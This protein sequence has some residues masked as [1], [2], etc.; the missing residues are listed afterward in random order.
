M[1]IVNITNAHLYVVFLVFCRLGSAMMFFPL[2]AEG[3][4]NAQA[5]LLFG[6]LLSYLI[7]PTVMHNFPD[8][9]VLASQIVTLIANE[10]FMGVYL[11]TITRIFINTLH[12]VGM[13]ISTQMGILMATLFDPSQ[14]VQNSIPGIILNMT[15]IAIFLSLNLDHALIEGIIASYN[16]F[17]VNS[18]FFEFEDFLNSFIL[19]INSSFVLAIRLSMPFLISN[20]LL[21]ITAG[22]MARLMPNIQI[23]F[24]IIPVQILVGLIVLLLSLSFLLG[25]FINEFQDVITKL[26][27]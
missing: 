3:G 10:V 2:F 19:F 7:Y 26:F 27:S 14:G 20:T 5:K 25:G 18:F 4:I 13:V 9:K 22:V 6:V 21:M 23:F 17:P 12:I 24:L 8:S 15:A 16:K 1:D 11:G